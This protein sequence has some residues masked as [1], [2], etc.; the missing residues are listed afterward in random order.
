MQNVNSLLKSFMSIDF[1]TNGAPTI[2]LASPIASFQSLSSLQPG[3][4][5]RCLNCNRTPPMR[6]TTYLALNTRNGWRTRYVTGGYLSDGTRGQDLVGEPKVGG[7]L[8]R[9]SFLL[10]DLNERGA[11]R[12]LVENEEYCGW[13]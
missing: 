5:N 4:N 9:D 13:R 3:L 2:K 12:V 10:G 6:G 8:A 1:H 11:Q 7:Q